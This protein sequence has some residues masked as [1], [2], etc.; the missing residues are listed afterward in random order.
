M[1][2]A[3]EPAADIGK[4]LGLASPAVQERIAKILARLEP[5]QSA[6]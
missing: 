1:R 6:G 2:L 5:I 3:G 4:T